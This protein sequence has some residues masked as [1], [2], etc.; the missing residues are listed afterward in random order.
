MTDIAWNAIV[1]TYV[2]ATGEREPI[3]PQ[4]EPVRTG[5]MLWKGVP[6]RWKGE[7]AFWKSR[8]NG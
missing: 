4:P 7:P 3:P 5:R 2:P 1:D 8:Q 6:M